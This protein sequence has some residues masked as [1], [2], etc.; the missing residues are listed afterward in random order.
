MKL[1]IQYNILSIFLKYYV[2]NNLGKKLNVNSTGST[3]LISITEEACK[4]RT[5]FHCV[6]VS[7]NTVPCKSENCLY[8]FLYDD[9]MQYFSFHFS[10]VYQL[11]IIHIYLFYY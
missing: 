1:K 10:I 5:Q 8:F 9:T 11:S 7:V 6:Q 2:K 3:G 4:M